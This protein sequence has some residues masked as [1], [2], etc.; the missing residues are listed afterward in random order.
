MCGI[1]GAIGFTPSSV[2][3]TRALEVMLSRGPDDNYE[4]QID[5]SVWMGAVRLAFQDVERGRQ[6]LTCGGGRVAVSLNGEVYNYDQLANDLRLK[7]CRLKTECDTELVGWM[8]LEYG[9]GAFSKL[10]GMFAL[11]IYDKDKHLVIIATDFL[12]QKPLYY[13]QRTDEAVLY[14]STRDSLEALSH[15]KETSCRCKG[16]QD[17]VLYKAE[18]QFNE[19]DRYIKRL[20][21]GQVLQVDVKS[22]KVQISKYFDYSQWLTSNESFILR[23]ESVID[24]V[25]ELLLGAISKRV[26][27][28]ESQVAFLSGGVD[29]SLITMM[30]RRLYPEIKIDT[31]TLC[32]ES[33]SLSGKDL[34]RRL[35]K[36]VSVLAKT[37]HHEVVC[38][39]KD[40]V[41]DMHEITEN[42]GGAFS[43]VPSMWFVTREMKKYGKYTLSGDGADELFGSYYTHRN[44]QAA[45]IE[46]YKDALTSL[47]KY[48]CSF[49]PEGIL[50]ESYVSSELRSYPQ[51]LAWLPKENANSSIKI[52]L[53]TEALTV[54]P[55]TVLTYVDRLSMAHSLEA[56]NPFLDSDLWNY[57]MTLPDSFRIREGETKYMLKKVAER[58][59]PREVV[60][61]KKEG[62]VYP[63]LS[64]IVAHRKLVSRNICKI[65]E[66]MLGN[67]FALPIRQ[68]V[69]ELYK[70]ID[71]GEETTFKAAQALHSLYC[72][73]ID[74]SRRNNRCV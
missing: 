20:G 49:W 9:F 31:F 54:F 13:C 18:M 17:V 43:A 7:G 16:L 8:Y 10:K 12:A 11:A 40:L 2:C 61:R 35:A 68:V 27:K 33:E 60:Y 47:K 72:I 24:R 64:Y 37:V 59:L 28:K 3:K 62:F 15:S 71:G 67:V 46:T 25:E 19:N 57:V 44:A 21:P 36:E 38:S 48:L 52:Q 5:D 65:P 23:E 29:S 53:I 56:R 30:L 42:F 70:L 32:Y 45:G 69:E 22:R 41:S 51:A 58:Y 63:V 66:S 6:P 73:Y 4:F 39:P 74:I 26:D 55:S 34:D 50:S 14:A 1:T